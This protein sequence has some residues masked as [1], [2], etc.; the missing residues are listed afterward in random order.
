MIQVAAE[1]EKGWVEWRPEWRLRP[2]Y[3]DLRWALS[4]Q[5][6]WFKCWGGGRW[7]ERSLSSELLLLQRTRLGFLVPTWQLIVI[8]NW[9]SKGPEAFFWLLQSP[10]RH[11]VHRHSSKHVIPPNPHGR[12]TKLTHS[13]ATHVP[14]Y[15]RGG[16]IRMPPPPIHKKEKNVIKI[17]KIFVKKESPGS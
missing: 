3:N 15:K 2:G 4:T 5:S 12:W 10:D 17:K 11:V 9:S 14:T 7:L 13:H 6:H 16:R 1:G 8:C